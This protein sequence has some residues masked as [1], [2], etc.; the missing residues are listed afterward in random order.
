MANHGR[1]RH[2]NG[3]K[4]SHETGVAEI[5]QLSEAQ[6]QMLNRMISGYLQEKTSL[7]ARIAVIN[8]TLSDIS[9]AYLAGLGFDQAMNIELATGKLTPVSEPVVGPGE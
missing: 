5:Q 9:G 6:L 4:G 8:K 1:M 3:H 7:E 2:R